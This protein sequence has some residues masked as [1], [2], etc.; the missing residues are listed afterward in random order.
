M[1]KAAKKKGATK[2]RASAQPIDR[3]DRI[4]PRKKLLARVA[5]NIAAS[6][7]REPSPS[8]TSSEKIAE[9]A[10]DIAEQILRKAGVAPTVAAPPA[11]AP[12]QAAA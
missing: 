6:I 5:G 3:T 9:V 4:D 12:G 10:V 8:L 11:D 1:T 2:V 7:V